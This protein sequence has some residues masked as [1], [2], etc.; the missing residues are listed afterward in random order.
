M[1]IAMLGNPETELFLRSKLMVEQCLSADSL[2]KLTIINAYE[3]VEQFRTEFNN[4]STEIEQLSPDMVIVVQEYPEQYSP[5]EVEELLGLN[6][7]TRW[8]CCLGPW[9]ESEGRNGEVWP[10]AV[11]VT[12]DRL[13]SRLKSEIE[14]VSHHKTVLP[15]TA[16]RNERFLFEN[17]ET[18]ET[19]ASAPLV[20][21]VID[22]PCLRE[23]YSELLV[24][25][26]YRVCTSCRPQDAIV[27]DLR[28]LDLDSRVRDLKLN[29]PVPVVGITNEI[30]PQVQ[31]EM[32]NSGVLTLV[33]KLTGTEQLLTAIKGLEL[34][35]SVVPI[36]VSKP[37]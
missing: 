30:A 2:E 3:D 8:I 12:I 22:D 7:L 18:C 17:G 11:C 24:E 15:I 29:G 25:Q 34:V 27:P 28:L 33:P 32:L 37:A 5:P 1:K 6:P 10:I 13:I 31:Q 20:E 19:V 35:P 23:F 14:V 16:S 4:Q 26:G 21:L 36:P 9:S